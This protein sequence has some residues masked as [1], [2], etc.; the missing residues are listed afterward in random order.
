MAKLKAPLEI[1]KAKIALEEKISDTLHIVVSQFHA[2][3][4]DW[5]V[6]D[7]DLGIIDLSTREEQRR[8]PAASRVE[9]TRKDMRL[10]ITKGGAVKE[11]K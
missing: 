11:M 5:I 10:K 1:R 8:M 3:H 6:T 2:E 9:L 4:P 7:S